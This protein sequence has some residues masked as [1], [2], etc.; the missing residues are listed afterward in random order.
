M[1]KK[2]SRTE[3]IKTKL[4]EEGKV[5]YLDQPE[6]LEAIKLMNSQLEDDRREYRIKDWNSQLSA[7]TIK[8]RK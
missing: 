3:A 1:I 6:H 8:L 4:R 5:S 2:I 7:S